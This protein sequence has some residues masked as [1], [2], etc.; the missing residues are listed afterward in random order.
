MLLAWALL[1]LVPGKQLFLRQAEHGAA[2]RG[3]RGHLPA[4]LTGC[5]IPCGASLMNE[6]ER[7]A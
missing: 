6:K 3:P 1:R 5:F 7:P 2:S 4:S